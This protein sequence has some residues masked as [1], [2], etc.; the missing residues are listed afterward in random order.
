MDSVGAQTLTKCAGILLDPGGAGHYPNSCSSSVTLA[1]TGATHLVLTFSSFDTENNYDWLYVYDGPNSNSPLINRYSGNTLPNGGTIYSSGPE[2]ALVFTSDN[3]GDGTGF[4]VLWECVSNTD[5]PIAVFQHSLPSTCSGLM[6]FYDRSLGNPS[7]WNWD[8]GDGN[9]S[10]LPSPVHTYSASGTYTV[11]LEVCNANGCDTTVQTDLVEVDP[12]SNTCDTLL[13]SPSTTITYV[14]CHGFLMDDGGPGN[15]SSDQRTIMVIRPPDATGI[16]LNFTEF[17]TEWNTDFLYIYDGTSFNDPLIGFYSGSNLP[18]GGTIRS[19]GGAIT[20]DFRVSL[21]GYEAGF[22]VE[23]TAYGALGGPVADFTAPD[24]VVENTVVN[25]ADQSSSASSWTWDFG[26]GNSSQLPNPS[27]TYSTPG[28]Y[29]VL[30]EVRDAAGCADTTHH[31]IVV[32]PEVGVDPQ[33]F[34]SPLQIWPNPAKDELHL[35]WIPST[36]QD[37]TWELTDLLGKKHTQGRLRIEPG[38]TYTLNVSA[39]RKTIY[40]LRIESASQ[41]WN[42]KVLIE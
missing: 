11:T 19:S 29:V 24:T 18:Q 21:L 13:A 36:P 38:N 42:H 9:T 25:F 2:L 7:S 8:F 41:S 34:S 5:P 20:L 37:L 22:G 1:P 33:F 32:D 15:Y 30:L 3:F 23:W 35:R 17:S 39:L 31:S 40:F 27:H 12:G 6:A 4:E 16:E 28:T 14:D 26:D 10:A